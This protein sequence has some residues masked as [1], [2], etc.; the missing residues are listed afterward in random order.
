MGLYF[1]IQEKL[2]KSIR[3]NYHFFEMDQSRIGEDT[4]QLK[5]SG[6]GEHIYCV[7]CGRMTADQKKIIRER[8]TKSCLLMLLLGLCKNQDTQVSRILPF[9][10]N[11]LSHFKLETRK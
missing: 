9:H 6:F 3:G 10:M 1:C 4:Y 2:K 8:L 5:K 7:L 11:A